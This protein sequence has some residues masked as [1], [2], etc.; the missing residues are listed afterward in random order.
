[1]QMLGEHRYRVLKKGVEDA[2][3]MWRIVH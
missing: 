3:K 2:E 1:M